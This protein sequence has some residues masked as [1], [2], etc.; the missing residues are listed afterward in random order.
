MRKLL[1]NRRA[2]SSVLSTILLI[3]VV[4]LGMSVAFGFFVTFVRD[5]QA[6]RGGSVMEL[7]SI[8]DVWFKAGNSVVDVWLYNYGK[9]GV[10]VN[11]IFIDGI[12]VNFSNT[13]VPVGEHLNVI[14][15]ATWASDTAYHFR[16][17][18]ERGSV[19][20]GEYFSPS[21]QE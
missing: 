3:L 7:V 12:S 15:S 21:E 14:M 10:K 11:S 8:E 18:T 6:G 20:E 16:V 5:Y 2:V 9:V 1:G 4:V 19:F 17:V 13:E